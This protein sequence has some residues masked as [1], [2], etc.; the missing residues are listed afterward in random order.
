META[1]EKIRKLRGVR[2]RFIIDEGWK[3]L[4]G[5]MAGFVEYLYRTIRKNEGSIWLATQAISDLP[6]NVGEEMTNAL[7]NNADTVVLMRRGSTKNYPDL[8]KYLS[9]TESQ[10]E[11]MKDMKKRDELGYR[12]FFIKQ[13]DY[14]LILRN[15]VSPK[16]ITVFD[17]EGDNKKELNR[18]FGETGNIKQC[19]NQFLEDK[20]KLKQ[21]Q[22]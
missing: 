22:S 5:E 3:I 9:L 21:L 7:V 13:A 11:M 17:S 1:L 15:E 10:V 2:K 14:A 4:K 16:T 19:V 20:N 8:K 18:L 6:Q 12:E